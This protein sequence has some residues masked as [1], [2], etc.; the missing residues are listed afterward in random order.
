MKIFSTILE[1]R[2]HVAR[3]RCEMAFNNTNTFHIQE[4][5]KFATDQI[6]YCIAMKNKDNKTC[7]Y[8]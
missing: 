2:I 4:H 6:F 7:G 8:Y 5:M 1:A 3:A